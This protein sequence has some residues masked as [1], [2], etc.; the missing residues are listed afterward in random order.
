MGNS[1]GTEWSSSVFADEEDEENWFEWMEGPDNER[2][3]WFL[4]ISP[5]THVSAIQPLGDACHDVRTC[6]ER[7]ENYYNNNNRIKD[8]TQKDP[9]DSKFE[10]TRSSDLIRESQASSTIIGAQVTGDFIAG[11]VIVSTYKSI[12]EA[13][14]SSEDHRENMMNPHVLCTSRNVSNDHNIYLATELLISTFEF[15]IISQERGKK[16][17]N[18]KIK[19]RIE[20]AFCPD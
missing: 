8:L 10:G 4:P 19:F 18:W 6:E 14:L 5:N 15:R 20:S 1:N 12:P 16:K 7:P 13:L 11:D 3:S 17:K 2:P 9:I